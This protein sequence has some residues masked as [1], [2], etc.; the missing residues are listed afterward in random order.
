MIIKVED[1]KYIDNYCLWVKL[2]TGDK[3]K[4]DFSDML[5]K[6]PIA[7]SLLDKELFREFYLDEWPTVAW[8]CGFD[9]SP[10]TLYE[11]VTGKKYSWKGKLA[12]KG[13]V[14]YCEL[15]ARFVQSKGGG[16]F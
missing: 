12:D 2:N 8:A 7:K 13:Q 3:G 6:Y 1:A 5:Y 15:F 14:P 4:V 9:I 16:T 11:K 10:E